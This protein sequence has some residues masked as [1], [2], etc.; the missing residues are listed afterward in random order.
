MFSALSRSTLVAALALAATAAHANPF[1]GLDG[2]TGDLT[3]QGAS[4]GYSTVNINFPGMIGGSPRNVSTGQFKG[5]FDPSGED[6][7]SG[8]EGDDFFRF[9]C[10]DLYQWA[11]GGTLTY[12]RTT[13]DPNT[14]D[15]WQLT[16]LFENVYPNQD[17]GNFFPGSSSAFGDF[18]DANA[19]A[20]MQLAIW[21]IWFDDGL[22]LSGGSLKAT[23]AGSVVATAQGYLGAIGN[24]PHSAAPGWQLYQFTNATNQDYLAATYSTPLRT[25]DSS[26]PLPGTLALLGIGLAGLAA[27]RRRKQ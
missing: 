10:I 1:S 23:D 17:A 14:T 24:G 9:F 20:A 25:Q 27:S 8:A 21:E 11:Y 7:T 3:F 12:A 22:S 6:G 19:S 2:V 13:L 5:F 26:V 15:G 4:D 16:R 18:P